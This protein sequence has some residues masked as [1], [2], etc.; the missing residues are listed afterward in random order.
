MTKKKKQVNEP[1][2]QSFSLYHPVFKC[3][4]K[5]MYMDTKCKLARTSSCIDSLKC[6]M[7]P[8]LASFSKSVTN[9]PLYIYIIY[10][11]KEYY[12]HRIEKEKNV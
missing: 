4:S 10:I 5:L 2:G 6:G 1:P 7:W 3:T 8:P 12:V 9:F 11:E